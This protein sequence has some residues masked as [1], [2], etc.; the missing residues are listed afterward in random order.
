VAEEE[1]HVL[2]IEPASALNTSNVR[3]EMTVAELDG[4]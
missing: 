3:G 4:I 1:A 2:L